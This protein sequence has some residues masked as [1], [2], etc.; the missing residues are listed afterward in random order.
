MTRMTK[1]IL[2][3]SPQWF[4]AVINGVKLAEVRKNDRNFAVGD[5]VFLKEYISR[6]TGDERDNYT[7][8]VAVATIT[9]IVTSDD[10][11]EG[12]VNGYCLLSI[13]EVKWSA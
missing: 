4:D 1:H 9:H 7:G 5:T 10:F 11:P 3:I 2:K 13:R 6:C 8:R 12:L